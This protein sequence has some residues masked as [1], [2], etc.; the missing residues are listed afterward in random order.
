MNLL[1]LQHIECEHPGQLREYLQRDGIDWHAVELDEGEQIPKLDDF[2][3]MWVMGGPMDVWDT[4]EHPW[5]IAEKAAIREW[6]LEL[7]RPYLGLCLG[8]QL[9]ADALGGRCDKLLSLIH[10]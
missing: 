10:I 8:H 2:D 1:V 5:L 6:V 3:A 7:K 9:L 4:E